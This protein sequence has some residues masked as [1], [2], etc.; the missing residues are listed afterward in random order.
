MLNLSGNGNY[1]PNLDWCKKLQRSDVQASERL[2]GARFSLPPPPLSLKP[3]ITYRNIM[4]SSLMLL[5]LLLISRAVPSSSSSYE[6]GEVQVGNEGGPQTGRTGVW[7]GTPPPRLD[8]PRSPSHQVQWDVRDRRIC[9]VCRVLGGGRMGKSWC[10]E[11]RLYVCI[12]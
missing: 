10:L 12:G 5:L 8:L 7:P 1:N 3:M 9:A 11:F 2:M 4:L 6:L